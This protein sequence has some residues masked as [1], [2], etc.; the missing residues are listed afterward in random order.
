M[1]GL[2]V[3]FTILS[4]LASLSLADV[5]P[6]RVGRPEPTRSSPEVSPARAAVPW[7]YGKA[8][9][10]FE[11]NRGQSDAAVD[12]IARGPGYALFLTASGAVLSLHKGA[13]AGAR[14]TPLGLPGEEAATAIALRLRLIGGRDAT[15]TGRGELPGMANYFAGNDPARWRTNIP[16][17]AKVVYEGV[18]P[19]ID[20]AYYGAQGQLAYD[21]S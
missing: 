8:S 14:R 7:G 17:Y 4:V 21:F 10:G 15:G 3:V 19:G 6:S 16:T 11:A 13:P 20:L 12:F 18:Y 1:R 5:S 9:L 2:K